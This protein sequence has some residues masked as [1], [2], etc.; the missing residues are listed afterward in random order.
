MS[1]ADVAR[2][3]V[4]GERE[5]AKVEGLP[6]SRHLGVT[7]AEN[8]VSFWKGL[9]FVLLVYGLGLLFSCLDGSNS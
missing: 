7:Q 1:T 9:V 8:F 6:G 5:G 2:D 4:R 3:G